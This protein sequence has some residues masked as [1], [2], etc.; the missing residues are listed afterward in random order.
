MV[1]RHLLDRDAAP[2]DAAGGCGEKRAQLALGAGD[3]LGGDYAAVDAEAGLGRHGVDLAAR[4]GGKDAADVDRG[5][6]H[7]AVR[8]AESP[9]RA[10]RRL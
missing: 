6:H 4:A 7:P 10:R 5:M 2:R 1:F 3:G 8:R 9:P